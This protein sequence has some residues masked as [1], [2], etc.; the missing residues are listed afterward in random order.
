M[1]RSRTARAPTRRSGATAPITGLAVILV[2][3]SPDEVGEFEGYGYLV[4]EYA[5]GGNL[6]QKLAGNPQPP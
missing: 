6:Q 4:L 1:R 5:P 2:N 3:G